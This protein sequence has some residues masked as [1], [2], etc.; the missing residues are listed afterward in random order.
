MEHQY[1]LPITTKI[2][3]STEGKYINILQINWQCRYCKS[4]LNT[5]KLAFFFFGTYF[6]VTPCSLHEVALFNKIF[7]T[8]QIYRY[9]NISTQTF[10]FVATAPH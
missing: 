7:L 6:F 9:I 10:T 4:Q 5:K 1:I 2:L 3:T 8:Y